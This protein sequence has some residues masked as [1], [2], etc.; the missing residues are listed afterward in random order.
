MTTGATPASVVNQALAQIAAQATVSGSPPTFD[1]SAA[2]LAAGTL[3]APTVALI[4]RQADYECSRAF[5]T[6]ATSG[7]GGVYPWNYSYLYPADCIRIRSVSPATWTPN[8]PV[9]VRWTEIDEPVSGVQTKIILC[10]IP[11]AV[12]T[13]TTSNVTESEW[14][15]ILQETVVR[16]LAAELAVALGGRP[17]F[18]VKMLE[19]AGGLVGI[20]SGRDS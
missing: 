15:S 19:I 20:G 1:N 6:L 18:G 5:A 12:L 2:G 7:A 8:D 17:D 4:L 16:T 10:N 13:Y 11:N 9:A 14:D 3:Y